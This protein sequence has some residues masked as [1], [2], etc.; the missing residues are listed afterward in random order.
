MEIRLQ[1]EHFVF[2]SKKGTPLEHRNVA[3]RGFQ[4][5]VEAAGLN[6]PGEPKLTQYDLRHAFASVV[7]HHGLA[8]VDLA[9]F[10]GHTDARVTEQTY[11]HPFDRA[12]TAERFRTAVGVAMNNHD[13]E[14]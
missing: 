10:M 4:A 9:T 14:S 6:V 8:A 3:K 12:A 7:A 1:D 11:I 13:L 5:A 2:C